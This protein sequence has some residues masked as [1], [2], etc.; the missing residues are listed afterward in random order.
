MAAQ[1]NIQAEQGVIDAFRD[2]YHK[3]SKAKGSPAQSFSVGARDRLIAGDYIFVSESH[4]TL[5]E[6]KWGESSLK[7][8]RAKAIAKTP[9]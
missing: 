2:Y 6:F 1:R 7:A 5:I 9:R 4:F 3:F 8:E